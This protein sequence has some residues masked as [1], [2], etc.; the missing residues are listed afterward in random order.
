MNLVMQNQNGRV[1]VESSDKMWSTGRGKGKPLHYS[2]CENLMNSMKRQKYM[3]P[4]DSHAP[5]PRIEGV[6]HAIREGQ[7]VIAKEAEVEQKTSKTF[8][9]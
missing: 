5:S 6:Q 2:C 7:T 9:N 8:S 4:E 3:T 1:I